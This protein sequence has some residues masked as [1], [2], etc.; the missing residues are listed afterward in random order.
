MNTYIL[1]GLGLVGTY[2]LFRL[3]QHP[4]PRFFYGELPR[5]ILDSYWGTTYQHD[6]LYRVDEEYQ[7]NISA[8]PG[9]DGWTGE[10]P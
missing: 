5:I 10:G 9:F 7:K 1:V 6:Y 4:F 3:L 2:I 8:T